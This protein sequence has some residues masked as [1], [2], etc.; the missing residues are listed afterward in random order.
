MN[1]IPANV[2][3]ETPSSVPSEES[4]DE[5]SFYEQNKYFAE[6]KPAQQVAFRLQQEVERSTFQST[7]INRLNTALNAIVVEKD[8]AVRE[9]DSVRRD[10]IEIKVSY[11]FTAILAGVG[12]GLISAFPRDPLHNLHVVGWI[13]LALSFVSPVFRAFLVKHWQG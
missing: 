4:R 10:N 2:I 8:N 1:Q 9:L 11:F 13:C 5:L 7:E 12:G 3:G 6:L